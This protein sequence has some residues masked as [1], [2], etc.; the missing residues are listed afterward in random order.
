[1]GKE[2]LSAILLIQITRGTLSA[3]GWK[4]SASA[5]TVP[6]QCRKAQLKIL[7]HGDSPPATAA[8][9]RD[10]FTLPLEPQLSV[11]LMTGYHYLSDIMM[12]LLC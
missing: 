6:R 7:M 8:N 5:I 3:A 2:G 11:S 9:F 4:E 12:I 1:M 10:N